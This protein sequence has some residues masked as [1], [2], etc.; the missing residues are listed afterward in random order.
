MKPLRD[1]GGKTFEP[2]VEVS[3]KKPLYVALTSTLEEFVSTLGTR[4]SI[5]FH[6]MNKGKTFAT[7]AHEFL[8]SDGPICILICLFVIDLIIIG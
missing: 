8:V 3:G 1:P 7:E 6:L 2:V 4:N 5:W